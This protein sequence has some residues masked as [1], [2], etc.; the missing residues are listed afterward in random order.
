MFTGMTRHRAATRTLITATLIALAA[1]GSPAQASM[2]IAAA[3]APSASQAST[4]AARHV[5]V[6]VLNVR[7]S[8]AFGANIV[9]TLRAGAA[10]KDL[11]RRG[12]W[13][14]IG[15]ARW[16]W[17]GYT[18]ADSVAAAGTSYTQ[19]VKG[20]GK[21]YGCNP[22]LMTVRSGGHQ[23]T[24][25]L[26]SGRV[27]IRSGLTKARLKYVV[28]HECAHYKQ[29]QLINGSWAKLTSMKSTLNRTYSG[30][31]GTLDG[32]EAQA[33]CVTVKLGLGGQHYTSK[34]SGA[35]GRAATA[36]MHGQMS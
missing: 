5:A 13:M 11:G 2:T 7:S 27:W 32:I 20:L 33:D 6:A 29:S 21:K 1:S 4:G 24:T 18:S 12:S 8:P 26:I 22:A 10:V 35:R 17:S 23:G 15:T 25:D 28:A 34:C 16:V 36:L 31:P 14:K 3:K 19:Y 9:G 30:R